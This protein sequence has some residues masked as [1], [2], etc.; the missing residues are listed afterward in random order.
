[1]LKITNLQKPFDRIIVQPTLKCNNFYAHPFFK[2]LIAWVCGYKLPQ[3]L[4]IVHSII[5]GSSNILAQV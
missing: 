4:I 2:L 3:V 5:Q 1:M